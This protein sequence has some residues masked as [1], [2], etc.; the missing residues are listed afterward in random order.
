MYSIFID[1]IIINYLLNT[2][3]KLIIKYKDTKI[4]HELVFYLNNKLECD[5]FE[6]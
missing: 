6:F 4:Y 5:Y 3:E 2:L 1:H